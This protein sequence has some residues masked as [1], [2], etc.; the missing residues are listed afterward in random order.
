MPRKVKRP[1]LTITY[2]KLGKEKARGQF[3]PDLNLIEIDPR[4]TGVD[5]LEILIHEAL[6]F[7]LPF[8]DEEAVEKTALNLSHILWEDGYRKD[9]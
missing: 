6:H 2:R 8:L 7:L 1:S 3:Y 4:L 5:H 9:L